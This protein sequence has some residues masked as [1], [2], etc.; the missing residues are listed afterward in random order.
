MCSR[1]SLKKSQ[2][3]CTHFLIFKASLSLEDFKWHIS[4]KLKTTSTKFVEKK[5][6]CIS[7]IKMMKIHQRRNLIY[8][9][10]KTE[11]SSFSNFSP[12]R[13]DVDIFSRLLEFNSA[14]NF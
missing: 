1:L 3:T 8:K 4:P 2:K 12:I 14:K 9:D 5:M 13:N 7:M 10:E 6:N 11:I